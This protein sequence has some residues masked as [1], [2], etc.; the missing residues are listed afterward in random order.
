[1]ITIII[2]IITM[3]TNNHWS[4][5]KGHLCVFLQEICMLQRILNEQCRMK[6]NDTL[7][8]TIGAN[9]LSLDKF[10]NKNKLLN[11]GTRHYSDQM[12][13]FSTIELLIN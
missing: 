10:Y 5:S 2:N 13:I 4:D 7:H 11:S 6:I 12:Q 8:I 3:T 9:L 1:M